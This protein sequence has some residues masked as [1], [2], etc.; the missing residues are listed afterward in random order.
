LDSG[1]CGETG[2]EKTQKVVFN[3]VER[4][5]QNTNGDTAKRGLP[6]HRQAWFSITGP[7]KSPGN[8]PGSNPPNGDLFFWWV[9]TKKKSKKEKK[10]QCECSKVK[11]WQALKKL[12]GRAVP[13]PHDANNKG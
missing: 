10:E 5:W 2:V 11:T 8:S 13:R 12:G 3:E 4:S 9:K 6:L 7:K 1:G